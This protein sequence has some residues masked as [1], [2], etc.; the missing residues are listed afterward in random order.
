MINKAILKKIFASNKLEI[1]AINIIKR[2]IHFDDKVNYVLVGLRRVGKSYLLF[3]RIKELQEQGIGWDEML[4]LNF[5]D[6]RLSGF[7]A[8]DFDLLI[9]THIEM[10]GKRPILFLDEIQNVE[11]WH[12]FA[13]RMAD[14]K[15][16]IYITGSNAKMLSSEVMT[17]LGGRFIER[18]VYPF[19][20]EEY[21]IAK[22]VDFSETAI[23]ATQTKAE[24]IRNF[25]NYIT[26]GGLPETIYQPSTRD[27]L[28]S[29]YQ[30]IYLGDIIARNSVAN[31]NGIRLM[32]RKM[33]ES[34]MQPVSFNRITQI[35][36]SVGGKVSL[37]TIIKYVE[38]AIDACLILKV[39]NISGHLSEKETNCKYYF[40]DNGIL[41]LFL[42]DGISLLLENIVAMS[43]IKKY[44][45]SDNVF[46]Y[47]DNKN[48]VD[49]YVPE[50]TLAIQVSCVMQNDDTFIRETKALTNLPKVLECSRRLVITL[51]DEYEITDQVGK[52][53]VLPCWKWLLEI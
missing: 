30:K 47:N 15:Y 41:N 4:Y 12:K 1:N 51:D 2:N 32:L 20:F 34:V 46:F 19:T 39:K 40:A 49:F 28:N 26:Y 23:W 44:G 9:E 42:I 43:L 38:Y 29:V 33:A 22:N 13:R 18:D 10:Y 11:N 25:N 45:N 7:D 36:S 35:L 37:A 21:L 3:Q 5:E 48:E 6:E 52:I 8:M 24:I 53:E 31:S 50:Q 16:T 14:S 17:T 27:Y